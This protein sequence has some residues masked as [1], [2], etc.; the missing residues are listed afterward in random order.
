MS[1]INRLTSVHYPKRK[2]FKEEEYEE[3]FSDIIGFEDV[4]KLLL[5]CIY[6]KEPIHVLLLGRPASSK[7]LFLLQMEKRLH[8]KDNKTLFVDGTS[9]NGPGIADL[10]FANDSL[11]YLLIDELDKLSKGNQANLLNLME[12]SMLVE[13][14]VGKT[15]QKYMEESVFATCNE[16]EKISLPLKS[17]FIVVHLPEYT[18]EELIEISE[19]LLWRKYSIRQEL[20]RTI[21]KSLWNS[22]S[23]DVRDLLKIAKLARN[24]EEVDW[25]VKT[26]IGY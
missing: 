25:L 21:A 23:R 5:R 11:R 22:G 15:R 10:L 2:D 24:E 13:T 1:W 14:K 19:S 20:A 8:S 9:A 4:K 7:T 12:N 17:R 16:I 6:T 3:F 26:I 18:F